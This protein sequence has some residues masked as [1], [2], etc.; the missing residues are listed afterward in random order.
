[1]P[2]LTSLGVPLYNGMVNRI[3]LA[4]LIVWSIATT[5]QADARNPYTYQLAN[6]MTVILS[7][8]P[9][10]QATCV[11]TYHKNGVRHD[12]P[13]IRGASFLYQ[14]LM[15]LGTEN[16][17]DYERL[18]FI[19]KNAGES[20]AQ[21]GMDYAY[22]AQLIPDHT[23]ANALWL[24][25]ER[26]SSLLFFDQSLNS[27]KRNLYQR[28]SA[29]LEENVMFRAQEWVRSRI[30]ENTVYQEPVFGSLDIL[31][32]LENNSIRS[33]YGVFRNPRNIILVICGSVKIR[34]AI[35]LIRKHIL[36]RDNG[37]ALKAPP[38]KAIP[39]REKA[40]RETWTDPESD[41]NV[42]IYGFRTPGLVN[43]DHTAFQ[44]IQAFLSDPR[45]SH[46]D[47]ILNQDNHLNIHIAKE[48]TH[49]FE[50]N[51]F[52]FRISSPSRLAIEKADYLVR[53]LLDALAEGNLSNTDLRQTRMLMEIDL[54]KIMLDPEQRA[55]WLAQQHHLYGPNGRPK[56]M[57]EELNALT[58]QELQQV[59]ARYLSKENRVIL[60]VFN[61]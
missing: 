38:P 17:D 24:E 49:Q 45:N 58:I 51:A 14:Y 11:L 52:L 43:R 1:M 37:E 42:V 27:Q 53:Q 9:G 3:C 39:P 28:L 2:G 54:R 19:R 15:M 13:S 29:L 48:E 57:E 10:M 7:P 30:F 55:L 21:V 4:L 61:K 36:L 16:L 35:A 32:N 34:E 23:L 47:R 33:R 31:R 8:L 44:L 26:L 18:M 46:L 6:G 5:A 50:A 40:I 59:C 41:A 20:N 25:H 56:S 60:N 22:F 12:P